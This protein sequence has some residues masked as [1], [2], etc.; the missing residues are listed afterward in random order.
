VDS[1]AEIGS[2]RAVSSSRVGAGPH[3]TGVAAREGH[4]QHQCGAATNLALRASGRGRAT[5][6]APA[7]YERSDPRSGARAGGDRPAAH[8]VCARRRAAP[9]NL[10]GIA[11]AMR[12]CGRV[13]AGLCWLAWTALLLI[14]GTLCPAVAAADQYHVFAC[15]NPYTGQGAPAADW[16]YD[17]G[18]NGYGDGAG[19]SCSGGGGSIS[20]WM[21]GGITHGFGEGGYAT[22]NAPGQLTIAAF[23]L[24]RYE[25]V[26]PYEPY[27]APAT[28]IAYNPGNVSVEGLCAQ[29]LG[30]S[31]RGDPQDRLAAGNEV[32]ASGLV[33]ITQIQASAVCGGGPGTSYVCPTSNAENG[34]SAEVDLFAGDIVLNDPTV[35]AVSNVAGPLISGAT[36]SGTASVSFDA[37]DAGGPGI[38]SGT[39]SVDGNPVVD[40]ILDTNGGACQSLGGPKDGLRAFDEPQPCKSSLSATLTLNTA[41]L[42]PGVHSV[43][44]SVDDASGNSATVWD[45]TIQVAQPA[46][47][48]APNGTPACPTAHMTLLVRRKSSRTLIRYGQRLTVHGQL[49]CGTAPVA[50]AAIALSARGL[51]GVV[52]TNALG[53]FSYRVP[54]G[55]DRIISFGYRAYSTDTTPSASARAQIAV[56]PRI[57]VRIT[58]DSTY[59]GGTITWTGTL[60]GGP[61]PRDGVSLLVEVKEGERWQPFDQVVAVHG[62]FA[63]RYTFLRTD[64]ATIY[65]F[66]VALPAS[67][68]AGYPYRP[69]ASNAVSVLVQ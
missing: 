61:F 13:R 39:I 37:S 34:N 15:E 63:Y 62:R 29:S 24:W 42:P 14:A 27:A 56:L 48:P 58:P 67:G 64:E 50:D 51:S 68:A 47:P 53:G 28:N 43:L 35:P 33:G 69:G 26:G 49:M 20:A 44:V 11:Q 1:R 30:C 9:A 12:T 54:P 4:P 36:L 5:Q 22:F 45:G 59:N 57:R 31:N 10:L 17:Q 65:R 32:G 25:A 2:P 38:Y 7:V 16:S 21:D 41:G 8:L 46:Q 18:T 60:A 40:Q 66:R 52:V 3:L 55:P 6:T 19:S 23:T